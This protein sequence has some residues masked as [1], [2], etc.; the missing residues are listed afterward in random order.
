MYSYISH[1]SRELKC[2][3]LLE[4]VRQ[5]D[6]KE[7]AAEEHKAI[8]SKPVG[9]TFQECQKAANKPLNRLKYPN[10]FDHSRVVLP[11]EKKRQD[12]INANYVD[13]YNHERK[14][15]CM[16]A[17]MHHTNYDLWRTVWMHHSRIIVMFCEKSVFN[18]QVYDAYW[19]YM[20]GTLNCEKFTIK[21]KKIDI[22]STYILTTLE[23]TDG[24]PASQEVLHFAFTAWSDMKLPASLEDVLNFVLAVRHNHAEIKAKLIQEGCKYCSPPIIVHSLMGVDRSAAFCA[25]DIEISQYNNT[26]IISLASTVVKIREQRHNSLA[27][28]HY[29][30]FCYR[31]L[32]KY[33]NLFRPRK[34]VDLLKRT[35]SHAVSLIKNLSI[36]KLFNLKNN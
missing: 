11:V 8:L 32:A 20:Q 30:L 27:D 34:D 13:G 18:H 1:I 10:C 25:V 36:S 6:F 7:I 28:F 16:Q 29:Y 14:F 2:K 23:V 5:S 24:T 17:P 31:V 15:I 22:Q 35:T 9:G 19:F 12:Y 4:F 21:T 3:E 26:G 33:V